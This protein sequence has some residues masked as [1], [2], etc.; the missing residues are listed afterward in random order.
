MNIAD[1]TK[2]HFIDGSTMPRIVMIIEFR[3]VM[4]FAISCLYGITAYPITAYPI[5]WFV[6]W[7]ELFE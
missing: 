4:I 2:D 7:S 1:L 6:Q 5:T 3:Q